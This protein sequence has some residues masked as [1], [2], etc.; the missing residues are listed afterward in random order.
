MTIFL[1]WRTLYFNE[2]RVFSNY[3]NVLWEE[4][5]LST[6]FY[7]K[8]CLAPIV[9]VTKERKFNSST[10]LIMNHLC[11][12]RSD[13]NFNTVW[14]EAQNPDW[15]NTPWKHTMQTQLSSYKRLRKI[16]HELFSVYSIKVTTIFLK[17]KRDT[18]EETG[19]FAGNILLL[20][21]VSFSLF[22]FFHN[23]PSVFFG[24]GLFKEIIHLWWN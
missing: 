18:V 14:W 21:T 12:S 3:S 20:L 10:Y 13:I 16:L 6:S 9:R 5:D 15:H 2:C 4:L 7:V 23:V 11:W 19:S 17:R 8:E 22:Y 1:L 24:G